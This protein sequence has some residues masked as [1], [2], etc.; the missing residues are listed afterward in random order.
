ML[1]CF[2]E[3]IRIHQKNKDFG[4]FAGGD[5]GILEERKEME[6]GTAAVDTALF[7]SARICQQAGARWDRRAH[8]PP[9]NDTGHAEK[10]ENILGDRH[11]SKQIL[12]RKC[13]RSISKRRR[14]NVQV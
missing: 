4:W 6:C 10:P 3:K 14:R 5:I 1:P 7:S 2:A 12:V 13:R 9:A 11:L 8:Q